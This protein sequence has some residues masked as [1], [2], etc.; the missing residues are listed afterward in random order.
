MSIRED[1]EKLVRYVARLR[2]TGAALLQNAGEPPATAGILAPA[3]PA[4]RDG[5]DYAAGACFCWEGAVGFVRT[6]HTAQAD[7]A[8]FTAGTEA[9]Y[10]ARPAPDRDG[11][12]PYL[13]NMAAT[14]GMLLREGA[15]VYRCTASIGQMLWPPSALPGYFTPVG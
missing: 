10:G 9:L 1:G 12:Y 15:V 3:L 13:Y 2:E 7:W 5:R 14:E 8:P 6:A 4:W 11:V